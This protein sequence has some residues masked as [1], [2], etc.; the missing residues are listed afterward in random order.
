M[1]YTPRC[2]PRTPKRCLSNLYG[3]PLVSLRV[4]TVHRL[5]VA[6][7]SHPCLDLQIL[8]H[9]RPITIGTLTHTIRRCRCQRHPRP[10]TSSRDNRRPM[11]TTSRL[12]RLGRPSGTISPPPLVVRKHQSNHTSDRFPCLHT[13]GRSVNSSTTRLRRRTFPTATL[14][15]AQVQVQVRARARCQARDRQSK[16]DGIHRRQCHHRHRFLR[17]RCNKRSHPRS[18]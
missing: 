8:D 11:V 7:K 13:V 1:L 4:P 17:V 18:R 10:Y 9:R 6:S 3:S 14:G 15:P 12:H 16:R 5:S 2:F